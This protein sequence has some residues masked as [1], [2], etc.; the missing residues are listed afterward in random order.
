ML[1]RSPELIYSAL[2]S[3]PELINFLQMKLCTHQTVTPHSLFPV[4]P[5]NHYPTSCIYEFDHSL[6]T[7]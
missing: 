5:G 6:G 1:Y 7:H 2:Y 3:R 4:A